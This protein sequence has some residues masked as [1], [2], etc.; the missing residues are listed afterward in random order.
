V[1]AFV[2]VGSF[3]VRSS[4]SVVEDMFGADDEDWAIY[5]KIVTIASYVVWLMSRAELLDIRA[6]QLY[7]Q[8]KKTTSRSYRQSSR[9]FS[10]MTPPLESNRRMRLSLPN[11]QHSCP[12]S[13][14]SI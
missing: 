9:S 2:E 12:P 11:A 8:T 6:P 13:G 7:H 5:R 4:F 14:R 3:F 10:R 1:R